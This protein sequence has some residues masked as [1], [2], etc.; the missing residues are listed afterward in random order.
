MVN[1]I[2]QRCG[3]KTFN[4]SYFK[5]HLTRKN[6]CKA[7]LKE[8]TRSELLIKHGFNELT[9]SKPKVSQKSAKSKPKVSHPVSQNGL[10]KCKFCGKIYKHKQ[11]KW[12]HEQKCKAKIN[13]NE[14]DKLK[15][16][17]SQKD[18]LINQIIQ[19]NKEKNDIINQLIIE[20]SKNSKTVN[21]TNSHNKTL[22]IIINNYGEENIDYITEKT[23]KKLIDKPGSAIQ[24]LLKLIHFNEKYPENQNL[25]ITNIHDPYIHIY[26]NGD[27]K[28]K[29]KGKVIDDIITNKFELIDINLDSEEE[30]LEKKKKLEEKINNRE[31]DK[32]IINEVTETII[33]QS[34]KI[35]N[36]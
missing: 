24:K 11:S 3:Y 29:K 36:E 2:C 16:L 13:K 33:N 8:I 12:K 28:I 4:K 10:L 23:I 34:K 22:N 20:L 32:F 9:Q 30:L 19:D 35:F 27:W 14:N 17:L 7:K 5:K 26:D 1:Y 31:K 18:N 6:I 21:N 25:K 15:K